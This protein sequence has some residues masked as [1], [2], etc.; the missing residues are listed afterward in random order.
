MNEIDI[1]K[2]IGLD[3]KEGEIYLAL[4][5][6]GPSSIV[7]ISKESG[8]HRPILYKL[9]PLLEEKGLISRV[10]RKKRSLYVAESPEKLAGLMDT[11][12]KGI[13]ALVPKLLDNYHPA[14]KKVTIKYFEGRKGISQVFYDFITTIKRGDTYYRYSSR[15]VRSASG[16][17]RYLPPHYDA[18]GNTKAPLGFIISNDAIAK[19]QE[20]DPNKRWKILLSGN[21]LF[22]HDI[23]Q[24]IYG[25]KVFF[26]DYNSE[27]AS[28]IESAA[29]AKFQKSIFKSLWDKL[30]EKRSGRDS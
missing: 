27:T 15:K 7:T 6:L 25:N 22:D 29:F 12:A 5:D 11:T 26:V 16:K 2:R 10:I 13:E 1:L 9:L 18:I 23:T 4:L 8:I 17:D 3:E 28:I 14:G 30:P 24:T 21:E 20:K 19:A